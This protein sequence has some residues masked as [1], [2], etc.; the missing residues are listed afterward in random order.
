MFPN[1]W[2][3]SRS[4]LYIYQPINLMTVILGGTQ[5]Y[6][7]WK[8]KQTT[9]TFSHGVDGSKDGSMVLSL[10]TFT[11]GAARDCPCQRFP[12]IASWEQ[13]GKGVQLK[14]KKKK[15]IMVDKSTMKSPEWLNHLFQTS[16]E[17]IQVIFY[18]LIST[19][20]HSFHS[21]YF[22]SFHSS[23]SIGPNSCWP[24][25]LSFCQGVRDS[26]LLV[27]FFPSELRHCRV[28]S[29]IDAVFNGLWFPDIV[30]ELPETK[31]GRAA[32]IKIKRKK[33]GSW[34]EKT[35]WFFLMQ[36]ICVKQKP[37]KSWCPSNSFNSSSG[38]LATQLPHWLRKLA[39]TT[40]TRKLWG[41]YAM[42][43]QSCTSAPQISTKVETG[44]EI[45]RM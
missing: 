18:P 14:K 19:K 7:G 40:A 38:S 22:I 24:V 4:S 43:L 17:A 33:N 9:K 34:V 35:C 36:W 8:P 28:D 3:P 45:I 11:S 37:L 29:R 5:F 23:S 12:T 39:F 42:T 10:L 32:K 21:G 13:N 1:S 15:N 25:A 2:W 27:S 6:L 16:M 30:K 44:L 31:E 26:S 41:L 20:N